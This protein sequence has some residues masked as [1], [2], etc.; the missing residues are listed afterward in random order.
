MDIAIKTRYNSEQTA[1][2]LLFIGAAQFL[3]VMMLMESV[4]PGYSM[5]DNAISDLGTIPET[6]LIFNAS[7]F[8]IGLINIVAGLNI[9]KVLGD[10]A[11]LAIFVLGGIGAMGVGLITLDSP[12]GLHGLFALLAFL[13][14]NLEAVGV[15]LKLYGG[16]KV[17]SIVAGI[18]GILFLGVMVL[19][20]SGS[21]DLSGSIGHGGAER[22]IAYPALI[23]M[24]MFG[25]YLMAEPSLK[26]GVRSRR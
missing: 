15:G 14:L 2:L 11:L 9:Y 17:I 20:D 8:A 1:G 21:I 7:L 25:G 23:W 19:V 22:M 26:R 16:L 24:V 10:K 5:H 12:L 4:A 18:V 13:F 3:L 6:A